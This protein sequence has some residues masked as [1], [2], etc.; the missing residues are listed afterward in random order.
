MLP[1]TPTLQGSSPPSRFASPHITTA[2]NACQHHA[3]HHSP[4]CAP[5]RAAPPPLI[6]SHPTAQHPPVHACTM[7]HMFVRLRARIVGQL[8]PPPALPPP[9][10]TP[11]SQRAR[12]T[13]SPARPPCMAAPPL[14]RRLTPQHNTAQCP[15]TAHLQ[16]AE[17]VRLR[18]RP[19]W[20]APAPPPHPTVRT[21]P[22][23]HLHH[24]A[25][26]RLHARPA[27]Q[28]PPCPSTPLN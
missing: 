21:A 11:P 18:A 17:H 2:P 27:W 26:A 14:P 15:Y 8:S 16:H 19:A 7:P 6:S 24:A 25:H 1:C 23:A 5:G 9:S 4:G 3:A 28:A 10:T 12:R 13:C 20:Q 22:R